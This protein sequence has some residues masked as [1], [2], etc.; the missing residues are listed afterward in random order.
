MFWLHFPL[1]DKQLQLFQP[2]KLPQALP[3]QAVL[4]T[5]PTE[6]GDLH[7]APEV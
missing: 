2:L 5:L 6:H 7:S 4:P 1:M 3:R